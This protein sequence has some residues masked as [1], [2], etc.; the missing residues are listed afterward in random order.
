MGP[1]GF[2][3]FKADYDPSAEKT[4]IIPLIPPR[5]Q[6][7]ECDQFLFNEQ[8]TLLGG[9]STIESPD[10]GWQAVEVD[11]MT[12]LETAMVTGD[13]SAYLQ[14]CIYADA[15]NALEEGRSQ[16]DWPLLSSVDADF[17]QDYTGECAIVRL[18][19]RDDL[20]DGLYDAQVQ[21]S[22][23]AGGVVLRQ[24]GAGHHPDGVEPRSHQPGAA[25]GRRVGV[26]PTLRHLGLW[27]RRRARALRLSLRHLRRRWHPRQWWSLLQPGPRRLPGRRSAVVE[28]DRA[29]T[30]Q[31][32]SKRAS[33]PS[34]GAPSTRWT[35]STCSPTPSATRPAATAPTAPLAPTAR[36]AEGPDDLVGLYWGSPGDCDTC[37]DGIDNNCNGVMDCAEPA[38][39]RCFVGQGSGCGGGTDVP[40]A[41]GGCASVTSAPTRRPSPTGTLV[42]LLGLI[43]VGYRVR[44]SR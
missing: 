8:A 41:Q 44:E 18:Q 21:A 40:C 22:L 6:A 14:Y 4:R 5:I 1:G 13:T 10:G 30:R 37:L 39:A 20:D 17:C 16:S 7:P 27:R 19:L 43:A 29:V 3:S 9:T 12:V 31:S 26:L 36:T 2:S 42:V 34:A 38:C 33:W 28:G 23:D 24:A 11:A 32:P 25:A 35:T 15:C